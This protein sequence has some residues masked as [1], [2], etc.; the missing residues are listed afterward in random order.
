MPT[1]FAAAVAPLEIPT[2]LAEPMD[3]RAQELAVRYGEITARGLLRA[4]IEH[5]FAGRIALV[6]SFGA[7]SVVLLHLVAQVDRSLPVLFL[8]TG[9]LFG[10]TL[11]YRDA[12]V[13]R[14]G[15][16]DV[17]E[18]TPHTADIAA[19]DPDGMLFSRNPDLCCH[20]R[21]IAPLHE[22]LEGFSAWITG[23]KR[24]QSTTRL[25]L[26]RIEAID[27]RIKINPLA[28]WD[29]DRIEAYFAAQ[30]LPR[31][32]LDADGFVSIGC[33]PCTDRIAAGETGRGGRWRGHAKTE[34]GIHDRVE[35]NV[36]APAVRAW[37]RSISEA[38][39]SVL[40]PSDSDQP[41]LTVDGGQPG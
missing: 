12:L 9:K 3:G 41:P 14:L 11:R 28:H 8:N 32:P 4:V 29:R 30:D 15:L 7:E 40:Q 10:E 1:Q 24:F 6:S 33:M 17:R 34:C 25:A 37:K 23:R 16:T 20:L 39:D 18:I 35:T 38:A 36:N 13:A 27:G 21:K 22:A 31:H 5:E 26:D 19:N 2:A